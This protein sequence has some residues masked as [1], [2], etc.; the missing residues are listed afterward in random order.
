VKTVWRPGFRPGPRWG[1]YSA[2]PDP[3]AG[4]DG[5]S[6]PPPITPSPLSALRA[7]DC[8]PL[9][10][11]F[12]RIGRK[13]SGYGPVRATT[14]CVVD[15]ALEVISQQAVRID[16]TT[17]NE[18]VDYDSNCFIIDVFLVVDVAERNTLQ[19]GGLSARSGIRITSSTQTESA[20]SMVLP[21]LR[22]LCRFLSLPVQMNSD[23]ST[24]GIQPVS[25]HPTTDCLDTL[26]QRLGRRLC[27][28]GFAVYKN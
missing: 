16:H 7:S 19:I 4:G 1:A 17:C 2:P 28:F 24:F 13:K 18:S 25:R 10:R 15:I 9:G 27:L 6:C 14:K 8:G 26:L 20:M 3:L 23:W 22:K 11:S 21:Q 5:A 12:L